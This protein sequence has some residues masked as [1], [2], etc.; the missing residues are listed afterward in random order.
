MAPRDVMFQGLPRSLIAFLALLASVASGQGSVVIGSSNTYSF[1]DDLW[2]GGQPAGHQS[3]VPRLVD[4]SWLCALKA[5]GRPCA[6]VHDRDERLSSNAA[7]ISANTYVDLTGH[8]KSVSG[9]VISE[10]DEVDGFATICGCVMHWSVY[11]EKVLDEVGTQSWALLSPDASPN[12][13][14]LPIQAYRF[15]TVSPGLRYALAQQSRI[16]VPEAPTLGLAAIGF[17]GLGY[18]GYRRAKN[19]AVAGWRR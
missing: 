18:V 7:D 2:V 9:M 12:A 6:K 15:D 3:F 8:A 14:W 16:A 5:G 10:R 19:A 1:N 17:A 13:R 4:D 11:G